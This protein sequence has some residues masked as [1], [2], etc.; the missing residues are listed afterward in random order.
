MG[1]IQGER[2]GGGI[3]NT[4]GWEGESIVFNA[5]GYAINLLGYHC[6]RAKHSNP[7]TTNECP[8]ESYSL[9]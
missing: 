6:G 9:D 7:R 2:V 1:G 8:S 3:R 5:F 4:R